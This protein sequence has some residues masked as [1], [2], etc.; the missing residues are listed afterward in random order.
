[1][2][3]NTIT[4]ALE[5]SDQ[6]ARETA[7]QRAERLE[8]LALETGVDPHTLYETEEAM[9]TAVEIARQET[10]RDIDSDVN[11][12]LSLAPMFLPPEIDPEDL[13]H[14]SADALSKLFALK[15]VEDPQALAGGVLA[16]YGMCD[17]LGLFEQVDTEAHE[18]VDRVL[19]GVDER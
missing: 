10:N 15:M 6:L 9:R 11:Q 16:L 18:V 8:A 1:M 19:D 2:N 12:L 3:T 4:E 13:S 5:K 14:L 17:R 7:E